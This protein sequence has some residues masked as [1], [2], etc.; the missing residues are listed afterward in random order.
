MATTKNSLIFLNIRPMKKK[1]E[2]KEKKQILKQSISLH[3]FS[4]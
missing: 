4:L 3:Q 2:K 1:R